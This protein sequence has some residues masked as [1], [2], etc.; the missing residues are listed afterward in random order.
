MADG[1][2][3][4]AAAVEARRDAAHVADLKIENDEVRRLDRNGATHIGASAHETNGDVVTE[5]G[6]S[7]FLDNPIRISGQQD[8]FHEG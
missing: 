1:A 2:A 4:P 5:Q 8:V 6:R 3:A 7:H